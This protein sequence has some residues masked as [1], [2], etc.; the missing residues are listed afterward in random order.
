MT[1]NKKIF[2]NTPWFEAHIYWDGS[3]GICCQESQQ[4]Y[5]IEKQSEYNIKTMSLKEWF[6]SEPVKLL[7]TQMLQ[8]V[9]LEHY[10]KICILEE[11]N[12]TTSRRHRSNQKSVIFTKSNFTDSFNQ[13]P[14]YTYFDYSF[15]NNGQTKTLPI[16]LHIDLGNHC[17]LACKMCG[18]RA[19]SRIASQH[20][21]WNILEDKKY[22]G[23]DWTKDETT[24][25]GFLQELQELPLKNVH[26]MGGETVL[27]SRL[28]EFLDYMI[29]KKRFDISFSFVTNGTLFD[30]NLIEKLSL[31]NRVGIEV[32]I[33]TL[34]DHNHYQ[35]QGTNTVTV[36]E[37]IQKYKNFCDN[38]KISLT[39]RPA[40]SALTIGTYHT[41]IK[42]CLENNFIIKAL[43][44]NYP[45]F[46]SVNVL[47]K[48]I[49]ANYKANYTQLIK[50]YQLEN[51]DTVND[52]NESDPFEFKRIAKTYIEQALSLLDQD[53]PENI[54][55]LQKEL[56]DHCKKW[57]HVYSYDALE[58]YPE[59]REI[60][61]DNGYKIL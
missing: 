12:S 22:I 38:D 21:K 17:N 24:W 1:P 54:T 15:K 16:D 2:C 40:I 20:V 60:F 11:K 36:L 27:S 6:N 23:S 58:L 59:L 52:F 48:C 14:N 10:C 32:S 51:L 28:H 33:E 9:P 45:S 61:I 42:Y 49:R 8:S 25:L 19:S 29:F 13:S 26:F 7:R 3:L 5:P 46:L 53:E 43:V 57:D 4:L 47:P 34:T 30:K 56:V 18:P 31:F 35:R 41:L 39:I 37:N 44:V 55:V 50:D